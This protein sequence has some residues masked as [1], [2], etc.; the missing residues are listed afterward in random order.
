MHVVFVTDVKQ[1]AITLTGTSEIAYQIKQEILK[2]LT[3]DELLRK[4]LNYIK[5]TKGVEEYLIALSQRGFIGFPDYWHNY[6]FPD[7]TMA[8]SKRCRL[9]RGLPAYEAVAAFIL[10]TWNSSLVGAGIDAKGLD[11]SNIAVKNIWTIE[12]P[13]LFIKYQ[14]QL[15]AFALRAAE[16]P[17]SLVTSLFGEPEIMT[18]QI[19]GDLMQRFSI[20]WSSANR[21]RKYLE[22]LYINRV[23]ISE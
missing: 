13:F 19:A 16:K 4:N 1:S 12:N 15:K 17:F 3:E 6:T 11:F 8:K 22:K 9:F 23:P 10:K 14:N 2:L 7:L 18:K 20:P 21:L 5:H